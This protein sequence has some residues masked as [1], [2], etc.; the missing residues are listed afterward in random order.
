MDAQA[1]I[2]S[3]YSRSLVTLSDVINFMDEVKA[4]YRHGIGIWES[5]I[6]LMKDYHHGVVNISELEDRVSLLFADSEELMAGFRVFMPARDLVDSHSVD[7]IA[8]GPTSPHGAKKERAVSTEHEGS[9]KTTLKRKLSRIVDSSDSQ[10][11]V[12]VDPIKKPRLCP[13]TS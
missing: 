2:Q 5:F 12:S 6:S 11:T 7:E 3:R 1:W 4:H 8:V 10:N 9:Q 13:T